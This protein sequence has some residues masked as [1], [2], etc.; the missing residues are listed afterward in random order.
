MHLIA[1]AMLI[2]T[3]VA[4]VR[5]SAEGVDWQWTHDAHGSGSANVF[6]G[7]PVVFAEG[8][9]F[10]A[11]DPMMSFSAYDFT[12]IGSLGA[13]A[14]ASGRSQVSASSP[15]DQLG[16][17]TF[18]RVSYAPSGFV[19]GD[20]SGGTAQGEMTTTFEFVM[21]ANTVQWIYSFREEEESPFAG[22]F[23]VTFDN[24][25]QNTTFLTLST[26]TP[27]V[28]TSYKAQTG[29]LIRI[30]TEQIGMGSMGPGSLREYEADFG[31][32][33]RVPEPTAFA[34]TLVGLWISSCARKAH[35]T[36]RE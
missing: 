30:T 28:V 24:V 13:T 35:S 29:D 8:H 1:V 22:A 21:P 15:G 4:P 12:H 34:L 27:Q 36:F 9:T 6:D 11:S 25:T 26:N 31:T 23:S 5:V 7:G 20:N 16:Y 32:L 14:S 2:V 10:D 17:S 3:V 19:G 18:F 33:F